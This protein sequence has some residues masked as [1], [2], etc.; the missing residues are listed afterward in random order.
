MSGAV[1]ALVLT[2]RR[3]RLATQTVRWLVQDEGLAP[4]DV[5]LV[6]NG[7]GGLDDAGL[8]AEIE[9]L[10][11]PEN[12]GPAGGFA[13]GLRHVL[14]TRDAP[15]VYLCEDD[16]AL[17]ELPT[18]R[19]GR[20][21]AEAERLE[22]SSG[23]RIGAVVA[24]GRDVDQRNGRTLPHEV[25]GPDPLEEIGMGQWGATLLS[26]RVLDAG[27]FPDESMFWGWEDLDFFLSARRAGFRVVV[28]TA[29]A[30]AVHGAVTRPARTTWKG[31]RPSRKQEP[32]TRYYAARNFFPLAR[33]HGDWRWMARH[34]AASAHRFQL[35]ATGHE[36]AAIVRG[37]LDGVRGRAGKRPSFVRSVGE[38]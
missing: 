9:V 20:L 19:T 6:V 27:V 22:R 24:Y 37:F 2:F 23:A 11:L 12:L 36:R 29:G 4:A 7:D 18:P 15:W 26:R 25:V 32:W 5:V 17:Y 14:A 8:Q 3:P 1:T 21:I 38:L 31:V 33:R 13:R 10:R 28:D 30:L 35:A 34:T 16:V